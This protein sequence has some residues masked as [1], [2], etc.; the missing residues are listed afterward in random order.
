M[1][2]I[3]YVIKKIGIITDQMQK[4]LNTLLIKIILP[5]SILMS[6]QNVY[7]KEAFKNMCI[8][9]GITICYY[10]YAL[11]VAKLAK[12]MLKFTDK[13]KCVFITMVV[14][15]N[16]G[17]IGF[18]IANELYGSQ[19]TLYAVVYNICYQ[20]IFFTYGIS[21]LS[22]QKQIKFKMI[23]TNPVTISSILSVVLFL[24][25]FKFQEGIGSGFSSVGNMTVPI[26]M[27]LIG[28][29]LADAKILEI[30]K[31]KYS[32]YVSFL[33]M[34]VLPTIMF[35][36]LFFLKLPSAIAGTC[37]VLTALPSGSLNVIYAE[38]YDC[39]PEFASRTVVQ[40]MVIMMIT[41]PLLIILVNLFL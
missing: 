14:F 4:G 10:I 37:A 16:V 13:G 34:L 3:G 27:I 33:R 20:L 36:F 2:L 18:P 23:Y 22:G 39:E 9:G 15:A 12:R 25:Q 19:G 7:T 1:I 35:V 26:S 38:Q 21:L 11:I 32:Y 24:L 29:S 5:L 8:V 41:I 30:A 6:S 17:F 31:D 28:A 40:T